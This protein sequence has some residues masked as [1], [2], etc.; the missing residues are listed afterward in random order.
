M[1]GL[2]DLLDFFRTADNKA[3]R[4]P[5]RYGDPAKGLEYNTINQAYRVSKRIWKA[6][7]ARTPQVV[8]RTAGVTSGIDMH[9]DAYQANESNSMINYFDIKVR[10][11][12]R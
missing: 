6:D 7:I 11:R 12:G 3:V 9:A 1:S 4:R 5:F 8:R 2:K 10:G